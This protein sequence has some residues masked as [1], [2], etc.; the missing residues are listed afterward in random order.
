MMY[1]HF[2]P[3]GSGAAL[4]VLVCFVIAGTVENNAVILTNSASFP[5]SDAPLS[6]VRTTDWL[7]DPSNTSASINRGEDDQSLVLENGLIKRTFRL[8]PTAGTVGF[9]N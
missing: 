3:W 5:S 9:D 4:F 1:R 6:K 8:S 2:S 7:I